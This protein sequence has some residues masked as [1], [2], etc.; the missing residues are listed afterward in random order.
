MVGHALQKRFGIFPGF[1]EDLESLLHPGGRR[2][3]DRHLVAAV[4]PLGAVVVVGLGGRQLPG[5]R[6]GALSAPLE[7][8]I[9]A[10]RRLSELAK[11]LR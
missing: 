5:I 3:R 7:F 9:G 11:C 2:A 10:L 4:V 6:R 1:L 8:V